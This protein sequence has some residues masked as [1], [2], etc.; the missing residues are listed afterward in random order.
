MGF[1][2]FSAK[3]LEILNLS[4]STNTFN[5]FLEV[6]KRNNTD[7]AYNHGIVRDTLGVEN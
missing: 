6:S 1:F 4:N 7:L 5:Q 2:S 3:Q